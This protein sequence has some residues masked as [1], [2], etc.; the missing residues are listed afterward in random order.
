MDYDAVL[1]FYA[2][3]LQF[4][5]AEEASIITQM[6]AQQKKG[7][8][9]AASVVAGP[10]PASVPTSAPAPVSYA[11]LAFGDAPA[12]PPVD[13][14]T[15]VSRPV[16]PLTEPV[17]SVTTPSE[18]A[19]GAA[20]VAASTVQCRNCLQSF[21]P[22]VI[23]ADGLCVTC[24]KKAHAAGPLPAWM[25]GEKTSEPATTSDW[26]TGT[27]VPVVPPPEASV[28]QV[29]C[30]ACRKMTPAY[31]SECEH[32]E[33]PLLLTG[34]GSPSHQAVVDAELPAVNLTPSASGD[35][36]AAPVAKPAA[37]SKSL[38]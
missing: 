21:A 33:A 37:D 9:V 36:P 23:D 14:P 38:I 30:P 7:V 20:G 35:P 13:Q 32:C 10:P 8:A 28:A 24:A 2:D 11:A 4:L 3:W 18:P 5:N 25:T 34:P 16:S 12:A 17:A 19:G 31:L 15:Q 6:E 1:A 27:P 22:S 26:L 29:Q